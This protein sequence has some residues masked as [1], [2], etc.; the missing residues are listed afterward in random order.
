M[1]GLT[2]S[3]LCTKTKKL[4]LKLLEGWR[5]LWRK[6]EIRFHPRSKAPQ[7]QGMSYHTRLVPNSGNTKIT[8]LGPF[9]QEILCRWVS[10]NTKLK[11]QQGNLSSEAVEEKK[12]F[13]YSV[14]KIPP[15]VIED[16]FLGF[17]DTARFNQDWQEG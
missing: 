6:F 15:S 13:G 12:L 16:I 17:H 7:L 14:N 10:P 4:Y 8:D 1:M 5:T 2:L 3:L 11:D 9:L